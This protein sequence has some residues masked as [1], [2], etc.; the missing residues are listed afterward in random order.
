[1]ACEFVSGGNM[2]AAGRFARGFLLM[3]I[4]SVMLSGCMSLFGERQY[5]HTIS[6]DTFS[7]ATVYGKPD[8][9]ILY[10]V[11]GDGSNIY[12]KTGEHA[13]QTGITEKELTESLIMARGKSL[14]VKWREIVSGAIHEDK[15][16]LDKRMPKNIEGST[17][18]FIAEGSQLYVFY[19]PKKYSSISNL[20][21]RTPEFKK[22]FQ[23]YPAVN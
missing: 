16:D 8:V 4:L 5:F 1:M 21:W 12:T 3:G 19:F 7:D 6:F 11:Y 13:L 17:I 20:K 10:W 18:H 23:I 9:Q 22:R 15:V 2:R 14:Y